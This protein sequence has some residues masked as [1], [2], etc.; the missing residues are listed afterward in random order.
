MLLARK[1]SGGGNPA[2]DGRMK[3]S[4]IGAANTSCMVGYVVGDVI[5][6]R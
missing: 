6:D 4:L 1:G 3:E 2:P 5:S